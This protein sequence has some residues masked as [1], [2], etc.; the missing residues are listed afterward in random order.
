MASQDRKFHY[1]WLADGT[2]VLDSETEITYKAYLGYLINEYNQ[3]NIFR[4][5]KPH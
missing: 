4:S 5:R 2:K 1:I 3:N